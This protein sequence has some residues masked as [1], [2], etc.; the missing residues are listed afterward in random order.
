MLI[1]YRWKSTLPPTSIFSKKPPPSHSPP[2]PTLSPKT[3]P[4][5]PRYLSS[6]NTQKDKK[7]E[8]KQSSIG[9]VAPKLPEP[10]E[11]TESR[12][13]EIK[14]DAKNDK[15]KDVEEIREY[16]KASTVEESMYKCKKWQSN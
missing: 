13:E 6:P 4:S 8:I 12:K 9:P 5:P 3:I 15:E 16:L 1:F 14:E 2:S 11:K 7:V 10:E